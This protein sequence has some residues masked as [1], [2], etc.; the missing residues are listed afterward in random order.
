LQTNKH[1]GLLETAVLLL[2]YCIDFSWIVNASEERKAFVSAVEVRNR[3]KRG[4][5]AV[6]KKAA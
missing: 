3:K 2:F 4:E 5:H 6:Q 1:G